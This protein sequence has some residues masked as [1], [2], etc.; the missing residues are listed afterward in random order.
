[1]YD[2]KFI[3]GYLPY[4]HSDDLHNHIMDLMPNLNILEKWFDGKDHSSFEDDFTTVRILDGDNP[5]MAHPVE[6]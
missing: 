1:M 6:R 2:F 4:P 5:E 3:N